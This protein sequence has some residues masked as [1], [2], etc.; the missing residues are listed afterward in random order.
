MDWTNPWI[1]GPLCA[2]LGIVLGLLIGRL[3]SGDGGKSKAFGALRAEFDEY[4]EGVS[5][6]FDTTS[7]LFKDMTEKYRDVY[8]HLSTGSQTLC[9]DS[10]EHARLE[11]AQ[12]PVEASDD[13]VTEEFAQGPEHGE[14]D[15]GGEQGVGGDPGDVG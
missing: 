7:E 5:E 14:L 4:R 1:T 12:P 8:N 10:M 9:E 2:G 13:Q 15:R 3:F 6:H 11:F